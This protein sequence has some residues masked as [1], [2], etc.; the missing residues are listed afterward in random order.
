MLKLFKPS[1]M[2]PQTLFPPPV[3]NFIYS[4]LNDWFIS[5]EIFFIII[6]L[7]LKAH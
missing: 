6:V 1:F 5:L 2:L 7:T 4:L 3:D